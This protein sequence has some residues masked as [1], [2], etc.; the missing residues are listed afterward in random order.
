MLSR[1]RFL[2]LAVTVM[3]SAC[4]D[5]NQPSSLPDDA[6]EAKRGVP[7]G[8]GGSGIIIVDLGSLGGSMSAAYGLNDNG[9]IVGESKTQGGAQH[10][11]VW[12]NGVMTDLGVLAGTTHSIAYDINESGVVVGASGFRPV[13]W[14]PIAGGRYGTAQDL[15]SLGGCCGDAQAINDGGQITG[16]SGHVI[17]QAAP[18]PPDTAGHAYLWQGGA[19]SDIHPLTLFAESAQTFP[20]AINNAGTVVGQQY[21]P[22]RGFYRHSDGS[23]HLL[24]GLGGA[25]SVP[26]DINT[27]GTIVG[28]SQATPSDQ[29]WRATLWSN[30][31]PQDLGTLGG[32]SSVAIAISD[33]LSPRVVGRADTRGGQRAFVW[34]EGQGMKDLGL[35][36]GGYF[37]QAWDINATGWIVGE[38]STNGGRTQAILWK[39][40]AP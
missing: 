36:K 17:A 18:T 7:G 8:G 30:G 22:S 28:W 27:A 6:P 33:G 37:G 15:G 12:S 14:L 23:A 19:M 26:I 35:P 16:Y 1:N 9:L 11:F 32:T 25:G 39:L 2:A 3:L 20:W 34:T 4:A 10:A 21:D 40:P 13:R 29:P 38:T 5:A 24:A 31:V